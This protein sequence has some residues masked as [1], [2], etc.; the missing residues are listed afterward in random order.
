V[1]ALDGRED[2]HTRLLYVAATRAE[3]V[4]VISRW[5]KKRG[6]P[7]WQAFEAHLDRVHAPEL[8]V[9]ATVVPP[10]PM[11]MDL[12][13]AAAGTAMRHAEALHA[14][15]M[16]ASWSAASVTADA[17]RFPRVTAGGLDDAAAD[18]GG[19]LRVADRGVA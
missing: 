5:R 2:E 6:T 13:A 18:P 11:T 7:A 9:P 1:P 4:L 12:S 16:R 17:K 3:D 19:A 8:P 14:G 15:A 10:Q